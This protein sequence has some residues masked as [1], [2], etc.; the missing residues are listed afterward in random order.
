MVATILDANSQTSN[1]V[2]PSLTDQA[3]SNLKKGIADIAHS[4]EGIR[5]VLATQAEHLSPDQI[6]QFKNALMQQT[7]LQNSM[8]EAASMQGQALGNNL[9]AA[10]NNL[11][12]Q[13]VVTDIL[14]NEVTNA[15]NAYMAL[16]QDNTDKLRMVEINRYYTERY[17]AQSDLM[18]LIIFFA[19]PLLLITILA[20]KGILTK[21]IAY[22]LG[23]VILVVGIIMVVGKIMDINSRDNM[24]FSE[25]KVD[26]DPAGIE[27]GENAVGIGS[28][29]EADSEA[30]LKALEEQLGIFCDG[31]TCC[32]PPSP[33]KGDTIYTTWNKEYKK[34]VPYCPKT[35]DGRPQVWKQHGKGKHL[36]GGCQPVYTQ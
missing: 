21:N 2:E 33:K 13:M 15:E 36:K 25:Y 34:C 19:V 1:F 23:G 6:K 16:K 7:E 4:S 12:N 22:I 28:G 17:R 8:L 29:I 5:N 35:A 30:A 24:D 3:K 14:Q 26:W 31:Q 27:A 32:D 20:N 11:V 9:R 10:S 18:K